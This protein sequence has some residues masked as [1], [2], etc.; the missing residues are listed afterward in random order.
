M[1]LDVCSF[2]FELIAMCERHLSVEIREL[3]VEMRDVPALICDI[4]N[5]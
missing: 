2:R 1:Q 3:S 4:D 5:S